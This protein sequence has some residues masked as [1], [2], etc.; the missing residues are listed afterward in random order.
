MALSGCLADEPVALNVPG[1]LDLAQAKVGQAYLLYHDGGALEVSL[2][3]NRTGTASAWVDLF[4]PSQRLE[5]WLLGPQGARP[6]A[7]STTLPAGDYAI[8]VRSLENATL[9]LSSNGRALA[10]VTE[11]A[12]HKERVILHEAPREDLGLGSPLRLVNRP[13]SVELDLHLE[14][15][16]TLLQVYVSET[17]EDLDVTITNELGLLLKVEVPYQ[18]RSNSLLGEDRVLVGL[19]G[20][21]HASNVASTNVTATVQASHAGGAIILESTSFSLAT[22]PAAPSKP[23]SGMRFLFGNLE[24]LVPVSVHVAHASDR[25]ILSPLP[26]FTDAN[27][28]QVPDGGAFAASAWVSVYGPDDRKLGT[29]HVQEEPI[30]VELYAA[31]AHALVLLEGEVLVGL[32]GTPADFQMH[33]LR[34][35]TILVPAVPAGSSGAYGLRRE[36]VELG[37]IAYHVGAVR[38]YDP[39]DPLRF[40]GNCWDSGARLIQNNQTIAYADMRQDQ[41]DVSHVVG[42]GRLLAVGDVEVVA[43]GFG[44]GSGCH[45]AL[46]VRVFE[47]P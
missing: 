32:S 13:A 37:G 26:S 1:Q 41:I 8:F 7:A 47:R 46:A 22:A 4:A 24:P 28:A 36:P 31:G 21:F 19:P 5:G 12:S 29:F 45:V 35:T 27:S 39:S 2:H 3:A 38:W 10:G 15:P 14:R 20:Q 43:D 6:L 11:L 23:A 18:P 30:A 33:P 9:A 42:A 40:Y 34:N 17:V 44:R 16:P 25:L